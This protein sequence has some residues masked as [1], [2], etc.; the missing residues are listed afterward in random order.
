MA[1]FARTAAVVLMLAGVLWAS[2]V[3]AEDEPDCDPKQRACMS[4]TARTA[5]ATRNVE[6]P[7]LM[8]TFRRHC[9]G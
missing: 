5:R 9:R 1:R 3:A 4:E 2:P 6:L 8:S 7:R